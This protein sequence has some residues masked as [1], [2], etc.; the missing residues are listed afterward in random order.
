M[1]EVFSTGCLRPSR[2]ARRWPRLSR[3]MELDEETRRRLIVKVHRALPLWHWTRDRST[4]ATIRAKVAAGE[5][6]DDWA[7]GAV[8]PGLYLST[9]AIDL[10]DRGPEVFHAVLREGTDVFVVDPLVFGVGF[11]E[12]MELALAKLE[13]ADA[14]R[15]PERLPPRH[16]SANASATVGPLLTA[17]G[18]PACVYV[19]GM[20]LAVMVRDGRCLDDPGEARAVSS[21]AEY[22]R[23]HPRERAML[24]P[25]E[26]VHA[27]VR[28]KV[29]C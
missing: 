2:L 27:W 28:A 18:V 9:S 22:V 21:V 15:A 14:W 6:F 5:R 19:L 4:V 12:L 11:P 1:R 20:H 7:D 24:V 29:G 23:E 25:Q 10:F 26:S 16:T 8:G 3:I 13:W 17:L